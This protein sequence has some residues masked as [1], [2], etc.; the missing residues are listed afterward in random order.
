MANNKRICVVCG[1]E[2]EYCP[3][4]G[5]H[6][7]QPGWKI[8]FDEEACK[9]LF[10]VI[11]GYN[12]NIKTIDDVSAVVEEYNIKDFSKYSDNIKKVLYKTVRISKP[13]E[14]APV[15]TKKNRFK[16]SVDIELN[17]SAEK[18]TDIFEG[19]SEE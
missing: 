9:K 10:D 16:K 6:S 14:E 18:N 3:K 17:E 19:I 7:G 12:M 2:Y 5:K 8:S 13:V 4:C 11:S 15:Q 1:A